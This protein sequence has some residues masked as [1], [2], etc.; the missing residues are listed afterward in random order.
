MVNDVEKRW[1][2]PHSLRTA[3]LYDVAVVVVAGLVFACFVLVGSTDIRWAAA[4]PGVLFA[5][6]LGAFYKTYRDWRAQR[7]WPIWQGAG[8][9]LLALA[10]LCFAVPAMAIHAVK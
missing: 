7:T 1:H 3:V 4:V 5:G 2:D 9:F 8:W 6:A 10:L